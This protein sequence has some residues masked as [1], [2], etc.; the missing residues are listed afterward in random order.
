[1]AKTKDYYSTTITPG[2][3]YEERSAREALAKLKATRKRRNYCTERASSLAVADAM[4][5]H[6]R[7]MRQAIA[8]EQGLTGK[9][10][11]ASTTV[12]TEK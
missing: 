6:Q 1:M 7:G 8:R 5:H 11:A 9:C 12:T 3:G 4:E 10:K 2:M